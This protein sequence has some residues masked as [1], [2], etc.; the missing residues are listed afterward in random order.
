MP[1]PMIYWVYILVRSPSDLIY[2]LKFENHWARARQPP[3]YI[4]IIDSIGAQLFYGSLN[5]AN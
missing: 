5:T 1:L 3:Y 2:I 4:V